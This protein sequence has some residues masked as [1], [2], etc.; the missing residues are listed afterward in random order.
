MEHLTLIQQSIL[1]VLST[2]TLRMLDGLASIQLAVLEH[3]L[4]FV[5]LDTWQDSWMMAA[6]AALLVITQTNVLMATLPLKLSIVESVEH[7]QIQKAVVN[8]FAM[9]DMNS[10]RIIPIRH[11]ST[12]MLLN[13]VDLSICGT[14]LH[15]GT[16]PS[17]KTKILGICVDSDESDHCECSDSNVQTDHLFMRR[18]RR[19][20]RLY[21]SEL[22]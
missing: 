1:I 2:P 19:V 9:L 3:M 4:V 18:Y 16:Y 14:V 17:T 20:S 22:C 6:S 15:K 5:T 21:L 12:L 10:I 8:A 7:I 13:T 11:A